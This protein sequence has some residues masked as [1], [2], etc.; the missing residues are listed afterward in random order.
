MSCGVAS[1][2]DSIRCF[3]EGESRVCRLLPRGGAERRVWFVAS[4]LQGKVKV[5]PKLLRHL[6]SVLTSPY[7]SS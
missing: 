7:L 4:R 3:R 6:T 5:M 1:F 2:S